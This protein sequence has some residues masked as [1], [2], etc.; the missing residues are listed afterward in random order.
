MTDFAR[1]LIL[2]YTTLDTKAKVAISFSDVVIAYGKC[3]VPIEWQA[4][5]IGSLVASHRYDLI[6]V[7]PDIQPAGRRMA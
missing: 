4:I 7:A 3:V 1:K 2:D 5:G 6:A